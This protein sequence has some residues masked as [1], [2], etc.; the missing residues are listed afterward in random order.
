MAEGGRG[1]LG[2]M[3]RHQTF[4]GV[5]FAQSALRARQTQGLAGILGRKWLKVAVDAG[6]YCFIVKH[7]AGFT[8]LSPPYVLRAIY[9]IQSFFSYS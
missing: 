4:G 2:L 7:S 5:R 8:L 3:F 6:V 1:C 9:T